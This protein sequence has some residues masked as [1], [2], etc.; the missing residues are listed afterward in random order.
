[1]TA[2]LV[3]RIKVRDPERMKAYSAAAGPTVAAHGGEFLGRG[4]FALALLG[5]GAAHVTGVMRFPSLD[6]VRGWFNSPDY[7]ALAGLRAQ[8]GEMEFFVY[9]TL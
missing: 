4:T 7:G 3:A 1:M 6:A 5:E 8:A 2:L 9:E